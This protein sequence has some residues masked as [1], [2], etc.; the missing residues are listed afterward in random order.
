MMSRHTTARRSSHI[1]APERG[2]F[3]IG[4]ALAGGQPMPQPHGT[5]PT[6]RSLYLGPLLALLIA[7]LASSCAKSPVQKCID[8]SIG[9]LEQANVLLRKHQPSIKDLSVGVVTYRSKHKGEFRRLRAEG[10]RL[11]K[12]I[13]DAERK[14]LAA[15]AERR[16]KRLMKEIEAAASLYPDKRL[17]M[18]LVR[19]LMVHGTP[20]GLRFKGDPPWL[21][22][23]PEGPKPDEHDHHGHGKLP[24]SHLLKGHGLPHAH[25]PS[26]HP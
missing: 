19:P 10:E 17:A 21:P 5:S 3:V 25:T 18:R 26:T 12:T 22:K 24:P 11:F 1:V 9:H 20:K 4:A 16:A 6:S 2:R 14:A 23:M 13:P 15:D 7:G 8:E